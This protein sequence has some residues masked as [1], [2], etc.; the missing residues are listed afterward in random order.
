MKLSLMFI[1]H[2]DLYF[3][4]IKLPVIKLNQDSKLFK[5]SFDVESLFTNIPLEEIINI[6][7]SWLYNKADIIESINKSEFENLL[8]L[9]NRIIYIIY[10]II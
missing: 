6:C 5:D 2:L 10:Y 9:E 7:I 1:C 8:F 3:Q 4:Q